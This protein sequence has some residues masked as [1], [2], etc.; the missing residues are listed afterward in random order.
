MRFFVINFIVFT[1]LVSAA[2]T[3][4]AATPFIVCDPKPASGSGLRDCDFDSL[5]KLADNIIDWLIVFSTALA[6]VVFAYAGFTLLTSGGSEDKMK[7]A[8]A[9]LTKTA[10]GFI[11]VLGAWLL[12]ST[13]I[14]ALLKN[15]PGFFL[16]S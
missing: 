8:K 10:I 9:M 11:I 16:L 1:F 3:A 2:G 5:I 7:K 6:G 15:D 4:H 12:I 14:K 13:I